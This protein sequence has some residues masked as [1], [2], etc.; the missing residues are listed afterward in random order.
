MMASPTL[1]DEDLTRLYGGRNTEGISLFEPYEFG[2]RCPKGHRGTNITWSEF[3]GHIWC[4]RCE[5]DY[6]SSGCPMQRPSWMT[7][8]QFKEF[9]AKLPFKP[10]I[11]SGV[12]HC[13]EL[14][15]KA[16]GRRTKGSSLPK[17]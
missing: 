12:D 8:Q 10:K 17:R 13:L 7:P 3:K 16:T 1:T 9:V 6:P 4:Y 2:Y 5:V 15:E 14:L 11:L